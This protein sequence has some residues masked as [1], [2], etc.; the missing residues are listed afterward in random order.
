[1][2]NRDWRDVAGGFVMLGLGLAFWHHAASHYE[3]GT[4][5]R[6]GP[7]MFPAALGLVLAGFGVALTL[8]ALLRRGAIPAIRLREPA[9]VLAGIAAFALLIRPAG[10]LPA[11]LALTLISSFAERRF[12]PKSLVALC[13]ALCAM[14]WLVF[15]LGLGLPVPMWR[16]PF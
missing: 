15:G 2:L 13:A 7:G 14:A 4:L 11:V 5:R 1:M 3:M 9:C 8:G 12:R 10:M 6:M 16:W